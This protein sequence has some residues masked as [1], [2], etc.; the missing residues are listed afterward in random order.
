MPT[1]AVEN[2]VKQI[3]LEQQ[4]MPG[5]LSSLGGLASAMNVV[6]GT[7]TTMVKHL[8]DNGLVHYEPRQGV[9]LTRKGE[10]LALGILRRHRLI[11]LFLVRVL[12]VD[13]SEVHAEAEELEHALSE[14]LLT[15]IDD[16]LGNP[17]FD[18]HGDPIPTADGKVEQ[19]AVV[20][21]ADARPGE[22]M[23]VARIA[24]Q[25]AEFLAYANERGLTP[26]AAVTVESVDALGDTVSL[27]LGNKKRGTIGRGAAKKVF[28]AA[29]K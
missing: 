15:R 4:R 3:F 2:Y 16:Y 1:I 19:R 22:A 5:E 26:G 29:V 20:A 11:E 10:K 27:I 25:D 6:P 18:P 17:R 21:L 7:V 13:W 24:D 23:V 14:K 8:A 12:N 28:V 9:K